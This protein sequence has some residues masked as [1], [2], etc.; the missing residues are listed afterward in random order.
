MRAK[1]EG[2]QVRRRR[3]TEESIARI[4][5]E[6]EADVKVEVSD[7]RRLRECEEESRHSQVGGG[8]T[9]ASLGM[10]SSSGRNVRSFNEVMLAS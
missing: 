7:V 3:Y 4:L 9:V 10:R 8:G 2:E 1:G 5:G 6:P